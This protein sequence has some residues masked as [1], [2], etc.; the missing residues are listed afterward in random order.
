MPNQPRNPVVSAIRK[1][2]TEIRKDTKRLLRL[3]ERVKWDPFKDI[4][5]MLDKIAKVLNDVWNG[6][7]HLPRT[8]GNAFV[9]RAGPT[10]AHMLKTLSSLAGALVQ[11]VEFVAVAIGH[12]ARRT[13]ARQAPADLARWHRFFE[14]LATL[15]VRINTLAAATGVGVKIQAPATIQSEYL[16]K[17]FDKIPP[18]LLAPAGLLLD[19]ADGWEEA[20]W[21]ILAELDGLPSDAGELLARARSDPETQQALKHAR[22]IAKIVNVLVAAVLSALPRDLTVHI[23]IAGE[24][25]GTQLASHPTGWFLQGAKLVLDLTDVVISYILD[26]SGEP[27][28]ALQAAR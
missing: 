15:A 10:I 24:G 8:I 17:V 1:D 18:L 14:G 12:L 2:T 7:T 9:T 20:P 22:Y 5:E 11:P 3:V 4:K 19:A 28:R 6:V 13:A 23:E 26:V 16:T 25:G 27:R 21:K